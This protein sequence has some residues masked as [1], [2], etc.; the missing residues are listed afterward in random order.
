[1]NETSCYQEE[2]VY[3]TIQEV[4]NIQTY[5]QRLAGV[6]QN[7]DLS[8]NFYMPAGKKDGIQTYRKI[9]MYVEAETNEVLP[10][11][12]RERYKK[13]AFGEFQEI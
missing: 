5:L 8:G 9:S 2:E 13:T 7:I 12:S 4:A 10:D 6:V 11:L 3:R 1:M